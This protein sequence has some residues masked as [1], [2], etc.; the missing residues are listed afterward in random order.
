LVESRSTIGTRIVGAAI[1]NG[2][3][4]MTRLNDIGD[5][6]EQLSSVPVVDLVTDPHLDLGPE[7]HHVLSVNA[8]S[9]ETVTVGGA[10]IRVARDVQD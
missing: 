10:D 7:L 6:N 3:R 4:R 8:T 5:A 2:I 9:H 1:R